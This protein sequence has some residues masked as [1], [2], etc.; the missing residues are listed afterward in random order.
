MLLIEKRYY[1]NLCDSIVE[2]IKML[3][4]NEKELNKRFTSNWQI[5]N[6]P[7]IINKNAQAML[8]HSFHWEWGVAVA[9]N[10]IPKHQFI[11]I[12][13]P[14]S[15]KVFE[16]IMYKVRT[17]FGTQLVNMNELNKNLAVKQ[18]EKIIWG[19]VADQNPSGPD[20]SHWANF[21][22]R[23][24]AFF[25][26]AELIARRY[27]NTVIFGQTIKLKRGYYHLQL[28][29]KYNNPNETK[30]GEITDEYVKFLE[31]CIQQ[32]PE[33]WVWSHRRWKHK[34]QASNNEQEA[35]PTHATK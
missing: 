14:I 5:V 29:V 12:Y 19:I 20:R 32:H 4:I 8:T 11:A 10:N 23:K 18:K 35:T 9:N 6:Q 27:N 7:E 1:H 17:R 16:K 13:N 33:N 22:G 34:F 3:S 31:K 2:T 21:L 30:N 28:E 15:S 24:T 26:G 25:K